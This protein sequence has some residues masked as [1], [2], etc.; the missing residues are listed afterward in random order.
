[1]YSKVFLPNSLHTMID[2]GSNK[3]VA[4]SH[5]RKSLEPGVGKDSGPVLFFY[6]IAKQKEVMKINGGEALIDYKYNKES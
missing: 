4:F 5:C 3:Y 2:E 6:D 1:M